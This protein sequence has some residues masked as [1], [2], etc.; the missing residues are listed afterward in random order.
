MRE[1]VAWLRPVPQ[2]SG[3]RLEVHFRSSCLVLVVV[4]GVENFDVHVRADI[5]LQFAWL[6]F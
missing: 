1:G 6:E 2:L 3:L 5:A 4:V